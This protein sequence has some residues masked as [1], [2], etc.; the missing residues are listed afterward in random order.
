MEST[1]QLLMRDGAARVRFRPR[2]TAD[3]YAELVECVARASTRDELRKETEQ[4]AAR[5]GKQFEF[6]SEL[7]G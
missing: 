7:E 5:W 6:D 2:L 3:E 1:L 4:A